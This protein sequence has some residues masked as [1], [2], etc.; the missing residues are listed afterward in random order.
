MKTAV[1][2]VAKSSGST[3]SAETKNPRRRRSRRAPDRPLSEQE[4]IDESLEESFPASDPPS[5]TPITGIGSPR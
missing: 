5:W 4:R 2:P 1:K 3:A